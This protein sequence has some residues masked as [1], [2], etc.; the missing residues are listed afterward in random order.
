MSCWQVL[1]YPDCKTWGKNGVWGMILNCILWRGSSTWALVTVESCF[2][3]HCSLSTL[4]ESLRDIFVL[5]RIEFQTHS[6]INFPSGTV[7]FQH[8]LKSEQK[9]VLAIADSPIFKKGSSCTWLACALFQVMIATGGKKD[10]TR[11]LL[12]LTLV[13]SHYIRDSLKCVRYFCCTI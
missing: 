10:K 9:T 13:H 12:P 4:L 6:T 11:L 8:N 2:C 3:C 7:S 5:F 1:E